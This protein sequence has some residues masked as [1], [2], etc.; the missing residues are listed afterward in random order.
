MVYCH[1]RA[2]RDASQLPCFA[3]PLFRMNMVVQRNDTLLVIY[4]PG[5]AIREPVP[6]DASLHDATPATFQPST[7]LLFIYCDTLHHTPHQTW[8]PCPPLVPPCH[9][10]LHCPPLHRCLLLYSPGLNTLILPPIL[11][12]HHS[13]LLYSIYTLT[14]PRPHAYRTTACWTEPDVHSASTCPTVEFWTAARAFAGTAAWRA[15]RRCLFSHFL[16][17]I[18][19]GTTLPILWNGSNGCHRASSVLHSA[20]WFAC[21]TTDLPHHLLGNVPQDAFLVI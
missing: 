6:V 15:P 5:Q 2:A 20:A 16:L 19:P 13:C 12:Y 1:G 21:C 14:I 17:P 7:L 4:A 11:H 10:L 3:L 18:S 9:T 8:T